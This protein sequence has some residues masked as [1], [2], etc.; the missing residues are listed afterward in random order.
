MARKKGEEKI[1]LIAEDGV[2]NE[3]RERGGDRTENKRDWE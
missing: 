3:R 1:V 2:R